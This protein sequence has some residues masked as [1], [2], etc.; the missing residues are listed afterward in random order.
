MTYEHLFFGCALILLVI[1]FVAIVV[2]GFGMAVA[3][4]QVAR[5]T[6]AGTSVLKHLF[7]S[8]FNVIFRPQ[9]LSEKGLI[10]RRRLFR[11]FGLFLLAGVVAF[12]CGI[13]LDV[14]AG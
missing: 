6:K 13:Y 12:L 7:G 5:N 8:P 1:A 11:W 3:S 2:S 14:F 10:A 4:I 9:F